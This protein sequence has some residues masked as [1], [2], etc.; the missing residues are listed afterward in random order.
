MGDTFTKSMAAL[1]TWAGVTIGALLFA[2]FWM[3]TLSVFS[4]EIDRWMLPDTRLE[5]REAATAPSLDRIAQAVVPSVP[6]GARQWRVDLPTARTPVM[7]FSYRGA[8]GAEHARLL[9]PSSYAFLPPQGSAGA[10]GFIVPFHYHLHLNW[11]E[12]GKWLVG[13]AAMTMLVLLV[14]GVIIHKKIIAQFF[15]FRPRKRL[16]R[17]ALDLHNLTGV[18]AL[19]FHFAIALS[20]LVIFMTIYFPQ[21]YYGAYGATAKDKAAFT[22]EAYGRYTRKPA[23]APGTLAPLPVC[24]CSARR[25]PP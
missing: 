16:Q 20:G 24:A 7:E 14:S 10:T 1:H 9:D 2:I 12:I 15:T 22:A 8:D 11:L 18:L 5:V 23:K 6:A 19:P 4:N 25:P 17:S 3:G 13:L 21:S